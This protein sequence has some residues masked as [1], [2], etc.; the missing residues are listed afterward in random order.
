MHTMRR[1]TV[2]LRDTEIALLREAATA[3]R[4]TQSDL[5]REGIFLVTRPRNEP[6]QRRAEDPP[7]TLPSIDWFTR[8]EDRCISLMNAGYSIA[9]L[10]RELRISYEEV[11]ATIASIHRRFAQFSTE[12]E[13]ENPN[14][15]LSW[16]G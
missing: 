10:G 6:S 1:T 14:R 11:L 12:T 9:D 16:G 4:R 7:A 3:T 15:G 5:I 8:E 2:W 13:T